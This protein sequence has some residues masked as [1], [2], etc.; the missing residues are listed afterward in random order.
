MFTLP[1]LHQR[2]GSLTTDTKQVQLTA[3]TIVLRSHPNPLFALTKG[4]S[5]Q[6]KPHSLFTVVTTCLITY[7]NVLSIFP[8]EVFTD[9]IRI[10]AATNVMADFHSLHQYHIQ[11]TIPLL[12]LTKG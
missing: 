1:L 8:L 6:H 3:C 9:S 10:Q 12:A 2:K 11:A 7:C 5:W 4:Y